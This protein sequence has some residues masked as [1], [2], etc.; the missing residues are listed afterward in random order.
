MASLD[1]GVTLV[2]HIVSTTLLNTT[3]VLYSRF[4]D[5]SGYCVSQRRA[6]EG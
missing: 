4:V 1:H 2:L 5:S 6:F 3:H